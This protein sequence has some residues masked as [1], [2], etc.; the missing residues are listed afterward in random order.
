[1]YEE[2]KR[3]LGEAPAKGIVSR[4]IRSRFKHYLEE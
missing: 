1:M 4:S 2:V 3:I